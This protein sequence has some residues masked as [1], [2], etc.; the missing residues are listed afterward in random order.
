MIAANLSQNRA[1]SMKVFPLLLAGSLAVN[2]ALVVVYVKETEKSGRSGAGDDSNGRIEPSAADS[3]RRAAKSAG[4][5]SSGENG[6]V[7]AESWKLFE[8]EDLKAMMV[9]LGEAGVPSSVVRWI[10]RGRLQDRFAERQKEIYSRLQDDRYW[11]GRRAFDP[12]VLA[13]GRAIAEEQSALYKELLGEDDPS[14]AF[15]TA[16]QRRQFGDLPADKFR[17]LQRI[18]GDYDE[19]RMQI[20]QSSQG[21]TLPEN[22]E[23]LAFIEKEQRADLERLLSPKEIEEYELRSSALSHMVRSRLGSFEVSEAEFRLLFNVAKAS[24]GGNS[25]LTGMG[26]GSF[27]ASGVTPNLLVE[28]AK[29]FLTAERLAEFELAT[30]P[31]YAVVNRLVA[32]LNL[33]PVAARE[34]VTVQQDAMKQFQEVRGNTALTPAQRSE[35]MAALSQQAS[36]K[37]TT[38]LGA[39]G[40]ELYKENGGQWMRALTGAADGRPVVPAQALPLPAV[41][42]R[43]GG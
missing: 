43:P 1:T 21:L 41:S 15:L 12:K 42:I 7:S 14:Q 6:L 25:G 24:T 35:Q 34:I 22:R 9:R 3:A 20:Q 2:A 10:V 11:T 17:Q 19:L 28:T 4:T 16:V 38:V 26:S 29:N 18:T 33:P 36:Q 37:L 8:G 5:A 30:N 23:K 39:K 13:E 40:F 32:H 27:N 31:Q